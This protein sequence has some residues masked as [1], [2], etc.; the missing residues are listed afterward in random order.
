MG[1]GDEVC[2]RRPQSPGFLVGFFVDENQPDGL[3]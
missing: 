1:G 2:S 3:R